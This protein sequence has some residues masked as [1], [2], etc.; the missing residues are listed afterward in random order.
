MYLRRAS[1][2]TGVNSGV[3]ICP[4]NGLTIQGLDFGTYFLKFFR[5][6]LEPFHQDYCYFHDKNG[7]TIYIIYISR[8]LL[9][10]VY[11]SLK[12][13]KKISIMTKLTKVSISSKGWR[14]GGAYWC[15]KK[16]L[17]K[18]AE[19]SPSGHRVKN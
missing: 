10:I 19:E 3:N 16:K 8:D 9:F 5:S 18:C 1:L 17:Y 7:K 14:M 2:T 4:N 13:F 11:I 6:I 15:K 12:A